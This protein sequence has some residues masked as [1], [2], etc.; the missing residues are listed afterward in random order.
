MLLQPFIYHFDVTVM[1][2]KGEMVKIWRKSRVFP[3]KKSVYLFSPGTSQLYNVINLSYY[4][5]D[6]TSSFRM[7]CILINAK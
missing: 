6:L 1:H 3:G 4:P 7:E 5:Y 2:K